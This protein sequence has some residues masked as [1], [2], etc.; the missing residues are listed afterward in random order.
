VRKWIPYALVATVAVAGLVA[1]A[2]SATS[3]ASTAQ[4]FELRAVYCFAPRYSPSALPR[5]SSAV[6]LPACAPA[7]LLTPTNLRV[8][9]EPGLPLGFKV[10]TVPRDALLAAYPSTPE[11]RAIS[12]RSVL[13]GSSSS[14][15]GPP[16]PRFLLGPVLLTANSVASAHAAGAGI[17]NGV[18]AWVLKLSLTHA[19]SRRWDAESKVIFHTYVATV[20]NGQVVEAAL[21]EP[22]EASWASFDGQLTVNSGW[23]ESEV[24]S[25]AAALDPDQARDAQ[26]A[27][28]A[29]SKHVVDL[30]SHY[31]STI[32]ADDRVLRGSIVRRAS[33]TDLAAACL[34]LH[35]DAARFDRI[36]TPSTPEL[37]AEEWSDASY[38]WDD[39]A[40]NCST[41]VSG[42]RRSTLTQVALLELILARRDLT[43][44]VAT[45]SAAA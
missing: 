20:V 14:I 35:S 24:R 1:A 41:A 15:T 29:W 7:S 27:Q 12:D 45:F 28:V 38:A 43:R 22:E 32:D 2:L 42:R 40:T 30:G 3:H 4:T 6:R 34:G 19:G 36:Q 39:A 16:G 13:L 23:R 5:E 8:R 37:A 26:V 44:A 31:L 33:W 9:P 18:A 25:L 17:F 11:S 10:A 21:V